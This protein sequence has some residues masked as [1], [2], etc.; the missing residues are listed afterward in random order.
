VTN[1]DFTEGRDSH[2]DRHSQL[3]FRWCH[4]QHG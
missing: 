2:D 1:I 3:R 4:G